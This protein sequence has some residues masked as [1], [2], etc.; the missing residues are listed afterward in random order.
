MSSSTDF[1]KPAVL[2]RLTHAREVYENAGNEAGVAAANEAIDRVNEPNADASA[3]EL[4][5]REGAFGEADP[6]PEGNSGDFGS[7]DDSVPS[8]ASGDGG[9]SGFG[10]D[11]GSAPDFASGGDSNSGF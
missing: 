10:V 7:G 8:F 6:G 5:F 9:D 2:D 4:A 3:I 11:T 1:Q